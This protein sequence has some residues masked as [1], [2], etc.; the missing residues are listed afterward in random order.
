MLLSYER[1]RDE[2]AREIEQARAGIEGGELTS[3]EMKGLLSR[4]LRERE[5]MVAELDELRE[6]RYG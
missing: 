6:A 2:V 4:L 1:L 5:L 3:E